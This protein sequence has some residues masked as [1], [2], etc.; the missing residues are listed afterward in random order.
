MFDPHRAAVRSGGLQPIPYFVLARVASDSTFRRWIRQGKLPERKIDGRYFFT[1]EEVERAKNPPAPPL[2]TSD[3]ALR[4][5]ARRRAAEAPPMSTK[6]VDLVAG[7][8][9]DSLRGVSA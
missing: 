7:A 2:V 4:A 1:W 9:V 8:F 6:Q 3:D 5:W